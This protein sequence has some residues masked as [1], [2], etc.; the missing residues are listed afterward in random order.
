MVR[1]HGHSV[2]HLMHGQT[3]RFGQQRGK[4]TGV[5][6][7]QVLDQYESHPGLGWQRF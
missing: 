3:G 4:R 7:F 2:G 6:R 5:V 1:L